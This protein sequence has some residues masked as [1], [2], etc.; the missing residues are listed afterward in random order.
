MNTTTKTNDCDVIE[1]TSF[2]SLF[3]QIYLMEMNMNNYSYYYMNCSCCCEYIFKLF[4]WWWM[5]SIWDISVCLF[6]FVFRCFFQ[7]FFFTKNWEIEVNIFCFWEDSI[8][9]FSKTFLPFQ[10][11]CQV[12]LFSIKNRVKISKKITFIFVVNR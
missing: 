12:N 5:M 2:S 4:E 8:C 6:R 9:V 1:T 3:I 11:F 10:N 7:I